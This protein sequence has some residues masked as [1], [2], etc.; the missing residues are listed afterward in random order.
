MNF[1]RV[2]VVQE[3]LGVRVNFNHMISM[4]AAMARNNCIGRDGELPWD[5]PEDLA[6][7]RSVT[8]GK[9]VIMGRKTWESLPEQVRPLPGR[10]NIIITRQ[11]DYTV[12]TGVLV[13]SDI[14]AAIDSQSATEEVMII[15]GA[16]IY[17]MGMPFADRLY[18]TH[19]DRDVDG[20]TFF[21]EINTD[22]WRVTDERVSNDLRFVTYDRIN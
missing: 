16:Q 12:P 1:L 13:Y 21:P 22:V 2:F 9:P 6:H 5:I 17:T 7:F 8:K 11:T 10:T 14:Q 4:I 20:D 3:A 15:G 18:I 19:V